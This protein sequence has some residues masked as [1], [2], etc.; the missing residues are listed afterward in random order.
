M[1]NIKTLMNLEGRVALITGA[2]GKI[3]QEIAITIAELGADLILVDLPGSD[4]SKVENRILNQF[5]ISIKTLGCNLENEKSR[6]HLI[7]HINKNEK[8][9]NI[10]INNAAFVG[11][12]DLEGWVTDF[13]SQ[14]I[15]TWRRAIEVNLTSVFHLS[16]GLKNKL[17]N[18]PSSSIIN[19]ASIYGIYGPDFSLYEGTE[20]G[21]PAAYGASK[22]GLI[23]FSRW[24]ATNLAPHIRVNCVSPGGVWRN[25]HD[26]F[27][28]RYETRTPLKRMATEED[29][30]GI[31]AYL[32]SDMSLYVTGQ[33]IIV[34]G[35][36]TSW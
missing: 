24:L 25:Q 7:D 26:D 9:L 6:Q 22:G 14:E 16:K 31:I 12:S 35:G 20:M 29:F 17:Q 33:N 11:E 27:V 18:S 34:D 30:K 32:A 13:E 5:D 3:G 36:W 2:T 21:N 8:Y 1:R 28:E 10:I 23:Q 19:I 4:F 15:S